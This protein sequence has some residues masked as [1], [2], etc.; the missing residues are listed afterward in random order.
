MSLSSLLL[1]IHI[2]ELHAGI[3]TEIKRL[4]DDT[5]SNN[6]TSEPDNRGERSAEPHSN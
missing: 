2:S 4:P 3:A 6:T 5:V 1:L